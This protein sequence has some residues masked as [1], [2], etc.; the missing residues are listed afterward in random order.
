MSHTPE[1]K[2]LSNAHSKYG[3]TPEQQRQYINDNIH[4]L[5]TSELRELVAA[6][7]ASKAGDSQPLKELVKTKQAELA[8][9]QAMYEGGVS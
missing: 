1:Q 2:A 5:D 8:E 4:L 9:L 7:R 6:M 3:R